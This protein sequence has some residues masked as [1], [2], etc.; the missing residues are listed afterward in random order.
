[1]EFE[2]LI[3]L[4]RDS[5][6]VQFSEFMTRVQKEH[7]DGLG[8]VKL[9]LSENSSL[10]R[11]YY[12]ADFIR[13]GDGGNV[14]ELAPEEEVTFDPVE[15]SLGLMEMRVERLQWNDVT[16]RVEGALDSRD[17]EE[18]FETW[19]DPEETSFD[20]DTRFSGNIHSLTVDEE[21]IHVDFGTAPTDA[22][23][24]L[25]VTLEDL[26]YRKVRIN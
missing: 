20:P 16:I 25:L 5:Y 7:G 4:V 26:G 15:V 17:L 19:F 8:E 1:M 22:L 24:E 21:G 23:V 11:N 2:D 10:Y 18:W 6:I 9:Q 14:I 12:C 3:E 13:A